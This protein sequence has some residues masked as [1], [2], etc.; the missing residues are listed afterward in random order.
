LT[1]HSI[2][3]RLMAGEAADPDCFQAGLARARRGGPLLH[4]L[5]SVRTLGLFDRLPKAGLHSYLSGL[6]IGSELTGLAG[7]ALAGELERPVTQATI[8]A[9]PAL[10][11]RYA[12]ALAFCGIAGELAAADV[13]A[14]GLARI[15]AAAGIG[16]GS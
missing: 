13:A 4:D 6:L 10:A 2:L 14:S 1:Q 5:F 12:A 9:G 15:A 7:L 11:G 16:E 3:G 8:I